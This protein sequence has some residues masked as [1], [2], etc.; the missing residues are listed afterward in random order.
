MIKPDGKEG[1]SGESK[2]KAT[3]NLVALIRDDSGQS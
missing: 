1:L 2:K 3:L